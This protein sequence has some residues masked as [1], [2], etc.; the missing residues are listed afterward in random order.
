MGQ[1]RAGLNAEDKGLGQ[2]IDAWFRVNGWSQTFPEQ[3]GKAYSTKAPHASQIAYL[4][5]R[6]LE[7]RAGFFKGLGDFNAAVFSGEVGKCKSNTRDRLKEGVALIGEDGLP[8]GPLEFLGL[9]V[10]ITP[11]P[12]WL[13]DRNGQLQS[14]QSDLDVWSENVSELFRDG[15]RATCLPTSEYWQTMV[16]MMSE[17]FDQKLCK[18]VT[19]GL[20]SPEAEELVDGLALAGTRGLGELINDIHHDVTGEELARMLTVRTLR[21]TIEEKVEALSER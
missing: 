16:K 4:K 9:Y 3:W 7:P 17:R 18:D 10:G 5:Q 13:N 15:V 1:T 19:L 12:Q 2:T 20:R 11:V 21:Q 8:F 14:L 6:K